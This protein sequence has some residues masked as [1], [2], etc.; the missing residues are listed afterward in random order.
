M[1]N[2]L[3]TRQYFPLVLFQRPVRQDLQPQVQQVQ[4]EL[5]LGRHRQR[6]QLLYL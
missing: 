5:V 2:A 3:F 6:H 4:P 1:S